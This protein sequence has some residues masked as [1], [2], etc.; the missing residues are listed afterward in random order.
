MSIWAGNSL[1]IIFPT[2]LSFFPPSARVNRSIIAKSTNAAWPPALDFEK[3]MPGLSE[4]PLLPFPMSLFVTE[5][6][7]EIQKTTNTYRQ[8]L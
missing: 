5:A 1:E 8:I 4:P 3:T 2:L 7:I 6:K